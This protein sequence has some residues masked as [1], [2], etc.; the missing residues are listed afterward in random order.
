MRYGIDL[1]T[2]NSTICRIENGEPVVKKTDHLKDT[3]PSC[4][5]F[6]RKKAVRVGDDA[7]DMLSSDKAKATKKWETTDEN[8]FRKLFKNPRCQAGWNKNVLFG[9]S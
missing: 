1:G 2:T 6:T 7:Y 3:L 5:A 4:V 8:V 9:F